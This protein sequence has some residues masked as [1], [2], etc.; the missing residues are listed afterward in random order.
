MIGAPSGSAGWVVRRSES[1][2]SLVQVSPGLRAVYLPYRL[3][4]VL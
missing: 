4:P 3:R 1:D 2:P